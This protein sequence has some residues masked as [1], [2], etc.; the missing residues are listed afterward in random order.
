ML[1]IVTVQHSP[2]VLATVEVIMKAPEFEDQLAGAID[3]CIGDF[4]IVYRGDLNDAE[5]SDP[6]RFGDPRVTDATIM[7]AIDKR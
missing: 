3:R 5:A 6:A 1:Q 2:D 7:S 4:D